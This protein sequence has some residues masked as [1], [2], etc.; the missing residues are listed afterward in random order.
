M[1]LNNRF[2]VDTNVFISQ[3]LWP[4]SIPGKAFRKA[5]SSGTLLVSQEVLQE[6]TDVL[7]RKKFDPYVTIEER[8]GFLRQ[9]SLIVEIVPH[10]ISL[11]ACRDSKDDKFLSLAV[12]GGA[13]FI[14]T[15]DKDLLVLDP[16]KTVRILSCATYLS[17]A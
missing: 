3:L 1:T 6:L 13:D 11:K 15:G 4:S 10:V 9:L 8:Q 7:G 12:S 5:L 17:R 14:L 16:F 2:I